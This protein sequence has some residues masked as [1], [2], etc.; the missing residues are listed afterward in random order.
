[1]EPQGLTHT[2]CVAALHR[3]RGLFIRPLEVEGQLFSPQCFKGYYKR[4]VIGILRQV[5]IACPQII[6]F[7]S[8]I[9]ADL[10]ARQLRNTYVWR[11]AWKV[12]AGHRL[13]LKCFWRREPGGPKCGHL[14]RDVLQFGQ[15]LIAQRC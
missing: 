3:H 13:R 15:D 9:G 4:S 1:M 14:S 10:S 8:L 7:A 5:R 12:C 11:C 2:T 6:E